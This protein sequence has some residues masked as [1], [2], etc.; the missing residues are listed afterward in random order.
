M[1]YYIGYLLILT[2]LFIILLESILPGLY[3]P[4][5][6]IALTIY[7]VM[8]LYAPSLAL[9]LALLAGI[10]TVVILQI[11]V[12]RVKEDIKIGPEKFIGR[13]IVLPVDLDEN[14]QALITIDN[15]KWH[16]KSREPLKKGD[17]VKIVGVEG[18]CL[19][20]EKVKDQSTT[21]S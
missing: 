5:V 20:V 12:Y 6:G 3:F 15:E 8:L 9:P 21:T 11:T 7:G 18:V 16:I 1:G 10:V 4:A 17:L 13:V 19:V 2:G 14:G